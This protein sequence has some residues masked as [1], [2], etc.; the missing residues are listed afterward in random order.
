MYVDEFVFRYN[1]RTSSESN[2]FNLLLANSN[3]RLKYSQLI[4]Q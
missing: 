4:N 1:T 2:R 3:Q